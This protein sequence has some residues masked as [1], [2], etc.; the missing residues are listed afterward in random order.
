M[1]TISSEKKD[2]DRVEMMV[3]KEIKK[4][5]KFLGS[6]KIH[7]GH[8]LYKFNT[9]TGEISEAEFEKSEAKYINLRKGDTSFRKTVIVDERCIYR[10]ALNVKNFKKVLNREFNLQIG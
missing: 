1:K 8:T 10:S 7:K 3:E 5:L 4:G 2:K 9:V 6:Q